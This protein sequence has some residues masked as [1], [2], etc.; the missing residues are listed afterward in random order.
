MKKV[1]AEIKVVAGAMQNDA[2]NRRFFLPLDEGSCYVDYQA[3]MHGVYDLQHTWTSVDQRGKGLAAALVEQICQWIEQQHAQLMPT[4]SY[5]AKFIDE[6]PQ[7][8]DL[9]VD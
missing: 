9:V 3:P 7:Y 6:H 4:C 2:A 8:A 1:D 5:I